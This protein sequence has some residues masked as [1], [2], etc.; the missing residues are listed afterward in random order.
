MRLMLLA[1]LALLCAPFQALADPPG[2]A[3]VVSA[4]GT[5]N[6]SP[7]VG[8]NAPI[9]ITA[10]GLEC[11]NGTFTGSIIANSAGAATAAAPTYV[12]GTS[13]PLSMNLSQ[14]ARSRGVGSASMS[15]QKT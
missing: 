9:T 1:A 13:N 3:N 11:I 15:R 10:T 7:Q 6:S 8:N 5:P 4:C 12:E 2:Y 14:T